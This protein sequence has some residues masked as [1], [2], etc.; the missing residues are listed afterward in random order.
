MLF[1]G[2]LYDKDLQGARSIKIV[3]VS[4]ITQEIPEYKR[5]KNYFIFILVREKLAKILKLISR[6]S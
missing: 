3:P 2:S 6:A 4:Y 1:I 5:A